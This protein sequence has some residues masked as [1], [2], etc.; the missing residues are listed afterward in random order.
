M[1]APKIFY[2]VP[3]K[4]HFRRGS[5]VQFPR[6][7]FGLIW[8]KL[9]PWVGVSLG[10]QPDSWFSKSGALLLAL[11][12]G[13]NQLIFPPKQVPCRFSLNLSLFGLGPSSK[14][15][16]TNLKL[17]T[18]NFVWIHWSLDLGPLSKVALKLLKFRGPQKR[19]K[20]RND[21]KN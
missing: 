14:G 10:P 6:N 18:N 4:A 11:L 13:P 7:Q 1:I 9:N 17:S 20:A 16:C 12:F 8:S 15:L 2:T 3:T 21:S 5:R 19:K